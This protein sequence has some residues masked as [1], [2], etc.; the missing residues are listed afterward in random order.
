M[1]R[2][3]I[4]IDDEKCNGCGLCAEGCHEGAIQM[5]N[6]K[7]FLIN[8]LLCDG[9]G[10]CVGECPVGAITITEREAEPYDEEKVMEH[11]HKKGKDVVIA[12]LKHLKDHNE[13]VWLKR[14]VAWMQQN[15]DRLGFDINEVVHEVHHHSKGGQACGCQGSAHREVKRHENTNTSSDVQPSTLEQW[16]VQ[17]HLINPNS[18]VFMGADLLVAAD[19]VAFSMGNFHRDWLRGRK[20]VIACPK[21]DQGTDVYVEK[22]KAL[23]DIAKVNTITVMMMEVPCCGGLLRMVQT[24]IASASRKVPVKMIIVGINGDVMKE[25]WV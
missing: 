5:I 18:S 10:V 19:C 6:G 12:H 2:Q 4:E 21:L 24:A 22:F 9:L 16:P 23:V 11:L 20:L 7:A 15:I 8:D 25:E 13:H 1:K 17:M 14:G 3:I